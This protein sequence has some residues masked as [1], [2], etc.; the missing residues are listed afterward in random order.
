M[1][2]RIHMT[3]FFWVSGILNSEFSESPPFREKNHVTGSV[4]VFDEAYE[5]TGLI[6][7]FFD[8]DCH[9]ILHGFLSEIAQNLI[10]SI[11]LCPYLAPVS[12]AIPIGA[13]LGLFGAVQQRGP[14]ASIR[15]DTEYQLGGL[16]QLCGLGRSNLE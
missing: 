14:W 3:E 4:F 8:Y 2:I 11:Q 7:V 16:L 10:R 5:I 12:A 6:R 9:R 13:G 15:T 1:A